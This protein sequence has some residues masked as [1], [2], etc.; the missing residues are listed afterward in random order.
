MVAYEWP[1]KWLPPSGGD[2]FEREALFIRRFSLDQGLTG[3]KHA[4]E[5]VQ[6]GE[7]PPDATVATNGVRIGV[8]STALTVGDMRGVQG[9]FVLLRRRLEDTEP[10]R[11]WRLAGRIVYIWFE[12][13]AS[14]GKLGR[15]HKRTDEAAL[16]ELVD[17]LANHQPK[18]RDQLQAAALAGTM[19]EPV[20]TP[21]GA[22]FYA[23]PVEN[24]VPST[25][26]FYQAGFEIGLAYTSFITAQSAWNE[27]QRLTDKHDQDGVDLLLVTAGGPDVDGNMFPSEERVAD[28]LIDHP[29]GL[30]RK[31]DHIKTIFLHKWGD[32]RAVQLYPDVVP[33]FGPLFQ[34]MVPAHHPGMPSSASAE[35]EPPT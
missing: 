31:P 7:D 29:I 34:P 25:T 5:D 26:L 3:S 4:F 22:R 30:S 13:E 24:A 28:F 27:L 18:T 33:L 1:L 21:N 11:F 6:R 19:P 8:E 9:L 14:Q 23:V 17:A 16:D 12:S 2:K 15:P 32:G 35:S 20:E 10:T